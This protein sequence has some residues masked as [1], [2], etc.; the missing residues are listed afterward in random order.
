MEGRE[1]SDSDRDRRYYITNIINFADITDITLH[2]VGL[3]LSFFFLLR[4][5]GV[6]E[7]SNSITVSEGKKER[8]VD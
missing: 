6:G 8:H 1:D 4:V 3:S 2:W 7:V 5:G